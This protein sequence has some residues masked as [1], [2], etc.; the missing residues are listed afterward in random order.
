MGVCYFNPGRRRMQHKNHLPIIFHIL[1]SF[2]V[3]ASFNILLARILGRGI[4]ALAGWVTDLAAFLTAFT[5]SMFLT[6]WLAPEEG[7]GVAIPKA[8]IGLSFAYVG[9]GVTAL[10]AA[11]VLVLLVFPVAGETATGGLLPRLLTAVCIHPV[12][13][14]ILFRRVFLSRLLALSRPESAMEIVSEDEI[15][16]GKQDTLTEKENRAG[17]LFALLTQAV[18]FGLAHLGSGGM[19]YGFAGGVILG[20]LMLRTGRLWVSVACHMLLNLRSLLWP[21]LG[22]SVTLGLDLVLTAVGLACIGCLWR[23]HVR[24]QKRTQQEAGEAQP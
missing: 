13:E 15:P 10:V 16:A 21:M 4:P 12:L 11:M 2:G 8:D 20:G 17:V 3:F 7:E 5:V 1:L 19:L 24:R 6:Y 14:E 18:L 9:A 22:E 23:H